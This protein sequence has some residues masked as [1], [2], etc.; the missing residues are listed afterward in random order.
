MPHTPLRILVADDESSLRFILQRYLEQLG[1]EVTCAEDGDSA[2]QQLQTQNYQLAFVDIRMPGRNGLEILDSYQQNLFTT[3]IV[4]ITAYNS[5]DN[6]IAAM[7]KGAFDYLVKPFDLQAVEALTIKMQKHLAAREELEHLKDRMRQPYQPSESL[8]GNA[9]AMQT[10][11][12]TLGHV[13]ATDITVL[14]QGESGT[15]K[16][17]IAQAIHYNSPRIAQPFI[18][19]NCA[20]IPAD[21]LENEL[22]GHERGAYTGAHERYR[23]KLEQAQGGTLFLDEIGDMSLDLQA[24]LL[25]VLQE[26]EFTRTGGQQTIRADVR[27]V[28]AT[29]QDL[30]QA[31]AAGQFREDLFYRL[32][33]MPL[34][35]PPL[36]ERRTDIPAL[37]RHFLEKSHQEMHVDIHGFS[38]QALDMLQ[39]QEWPGNIRQLENAVKR[40]CL[41]SQGPLLE[42]QD[43]LELQQNNG[44]EASP[45]AAQEQA[46]LEEVI[47][48]KLEH[49]FS[50]MN[51]G[52]LD[53]LYGMVLAQVER[54]LLEL[55]LKQTQGNQL[56]AARI[57]G[58]NRNTL[59]KKMASLNIGAKANN[60]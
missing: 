53:G 15:G 20:A 22:F 37:C 48:Q 59:R 47:K 58:I 11:Y 38:D 50:G 7:Q 18:A 55:V 51:L 26:K 30:T 57:L 49:S 41:L 31:I 21:L 54:P 14:I 35:L 24:K 44:S 39:Q 3:P 60:H 10:V 27:F 16:E 25:R 36:R 5:M 43:F 9:P 52:E 12:K 33:V 2:W 45:S 13:A 29:N 17:L 8:I 4:I 56:K 40:A 34:S 46:S 19:L 28:A 23:G 6:T 32:N 1:H 42:P